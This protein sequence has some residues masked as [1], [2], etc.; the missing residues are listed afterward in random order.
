VARVQLII[1]RFLIQR[2]QVVPSVV[3]LESS[4]LGNLL[5]F[6]PEKNLEHLSNCI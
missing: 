1:F 2:V 3:R 4:M 5:S 6:D